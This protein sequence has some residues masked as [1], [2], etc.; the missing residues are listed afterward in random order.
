MDMGP[1]GKY[2]ILARTWDLGGIMNKPAEMGQV[3]P[4]WGLYIL[5]PDVHKGARVF[6]QSPVA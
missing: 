1:M 6:A 4:H 2:H 5:V 3:P